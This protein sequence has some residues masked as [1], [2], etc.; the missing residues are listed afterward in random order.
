[1]RPSVWTLSL[2]V[3]PLSWKLAHQLLLSWETFTPI[4]DFLRL[5]VFELGACAWQRDRQTDGRTDGEGPWCGLLSETT[6]GRRTDLVLSG[7]ELILQTESSRLRLV[8]R[9]LD[10]VQIVLVPLTSL[11][12]AHQVIVQSNCR[13]LRHSQ[14]FFQQ[15][16]PTFV[17]RPATTKQSH[18]CECLIY[19]LHVS[20]IKSGLLNNASA[21]AVSFK[22]HLY[23]KSQLNRTPDYDWMQ[24]Y[25]SLGDRTVYCRIEIKFDQPVK[26]NYY[27][28]F[29][30]C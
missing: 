20:I 22:I 8:E 29:N 21:H 30:E 9:V 27:E 28:K 4:L 10:S 26:M 7:V 19:L 6:E 14:L 17:I 12:G 23:E 5:F 16:Q 24:L 3:W 13:L 18:V 1:M 11:L 25:P 15:P 2:T